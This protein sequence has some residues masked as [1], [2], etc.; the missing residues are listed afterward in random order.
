MRP[1]HPQAVIRVEILKDIEERIHNARAN[2]SNRF[3]HEPQ[4]IILGPLEYLSL[5][6]VQSVK[7]FGEYRDNQLDS[8]YGMQIVPSL[9]KG[10]TFGVAPHLVPSLVNATE[11]KAS[12]A[13][14]REFLEKMKGKKP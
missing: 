4:V 11:E 2:F 7:A 14:Y 12:E 8:Y 10:I 6:A 5:C 3:Y 9:E 1:G 13:V